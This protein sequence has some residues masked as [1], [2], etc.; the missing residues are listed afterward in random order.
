MNFPPGTKLVDTLPLTDR[1]RSPAE[2]SRM[3]IEDRLIYE[4]EN[5]LTDAEKQADLEY[6]DLMHGMEDEVD[7]RILLANEPPAEWG[8]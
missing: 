7:P 8:R 5:P 3:R 4:M 1:R 2:L 6:D